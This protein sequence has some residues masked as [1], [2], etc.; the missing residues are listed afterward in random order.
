MRART[1]Q[2]VVFYD[3]L[4]RYDVHGAFPNSQSDACLANA[5]LSAS[6]EQHSQ[7]AQ[8]AGQQ[9]R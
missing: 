2:R 6:H 1:R 9:R 7:H 5:M 3:D 4:D 8:Q